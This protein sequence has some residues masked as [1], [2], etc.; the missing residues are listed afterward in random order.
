MD[1]ELFKQEFS[2][3]NF[4]KP[5]EKKINS[6]YLSIYEYSSTG[7]SLIISLVVWVSLGGVSTVASWH[8]RSDVTAKVRIA[9]PFSGRLYCIHSRSKTTVRFTVLQQERNFEDDPWD[10]RNNTISR[11][12]CCLYNT[13]GAY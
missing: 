8:F 1:A 13:H 10:S 4:S 3:K 7:L 9:I 2:Q 6:A 11:I 12:F 5:E